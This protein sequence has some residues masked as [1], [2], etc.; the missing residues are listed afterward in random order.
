[1]LWASASVKRPARVRRSPLMAPSCPMEAAMSSSKVRI[2]VP[3]EQRT[4]RTYSP[5]AGLPPYSMP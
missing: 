4:V 2:Y 1:M 5:A 3:L